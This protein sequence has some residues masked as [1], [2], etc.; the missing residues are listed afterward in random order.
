M[1]CAG[2]AP[3]DV[4]VVFMQHG[5]R[6]AAELTVLSGG[7]MR[8]TSL[9]DSV[10][11]NIAERS[12]AA[13][14]LWHGDQ[15]TYGDLG[16]MIRDAEDRLHGLERSDRVSVAIVGKK[17]PQA[18]A[19]IFACLGTGRPFLLPSVDAGEAVLEALFEQAG[20][21]YILSPDVAGGPFTAVSRTSRLHEQA[22][23]FSPVPAGTGFMLTTSGSTGRPKI[24]P[25]PLR[26][27]DRFVA[28]A[29]ACFDFAPGRTVLNYAPLN[30]DLCFLDIWASLAWGA[31][32]A[33]VDQD[34]ATNAEH[35]LGMV[36]AHGVDVIQ[37]VPLFYHLIIE[38]TRQ[39]RRQLPSVKHVIVTGDSMT[40]RTL[41]ELPR[42]FPNARLYNLYGCTETNDSFL[43]EAAV[44]SP[45]DSPMPLGQPLSGVHSLIVGPDG[46]VIDGTGVGELYVTTPFQAFG[47]LDE[48]LNKDKFVSRPDG[49]DLRRYFRSGDLVRRHDDGTLTLEGRND[50]QIKVR[51]VR[52]NTQEV[53]RVLL[54][55][56]EVVE[57][58]VVAVPDAVAGHRLHA[59]VRRDTHSGLNS[60]QLRQHC[61]GR[62]ART[63]IPSTVQLV[64]DPLPKT[65][66]GKIDR[67]QIKQTQKQGMKK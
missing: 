33:L 37:A 36:S 43:H 44:S 22:G 57:A 24:V 2:C 23:E 63:A 53:E 10:R 47:Y 21:S 8:F 1:P 15:L 66:T 7:W 61:A 35:L 17:S 14:L 52:I 49:R 20:C 3:Q 32:V 26:A 67:N 6:V 62:L 51:G 16:A 40:T 41:A 59:V 5:R 54:E 38:A 55:H 25:I 45:L 46:E 31:C 4:V 11:W 48:A 50:F 39:K 60:L 58:A 28:W 34:Q 27:V 19:T 30:F 42:L 29:G 64:D 9:V 12:D 18:I 65:S 13:A 56:R